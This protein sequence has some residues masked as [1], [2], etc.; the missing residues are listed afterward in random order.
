MTRVSA[1]DL[2]KE[3]DYLNKISRTKYVLEGA[4]GGWKLYSGQYSKYPKPYRVAGR[5]VRGGYN[6]N[7]EIT[8]RGSTGQ[9]MDMVRSIVRVKEL[10]RSRR[11]RS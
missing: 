7:R 4:Y 1:K 2:R 10:E 3:V 5:V 8:P 9:V 6:P 11:R